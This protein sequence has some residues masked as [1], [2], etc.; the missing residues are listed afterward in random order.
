MTVVHNPPERQAKPMSWNGWHFRSQA[1]AYAAMFLTKIG[2]AFQYEPEAYELGDGEPTRPDFWLPETNGG[3]WLEIKGHDTFDDRQVRRLSAAQ[4]G[5]TVY[6]AVAPLWTR[7]SNGRDT[8]NMLKY[9]G[10]ARL[11][12][13]HEFCRCARCRSWTIQYRGYQSRHDCG[14]ENRFTTDPQF[15][16]YVQ[17]FEVNTSKEIAFAGEECERFRVWSTIGR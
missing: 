12:A 3:V 2:V 4:R 17:V 11:D 6:V 14:V 8:V 1:E 15:A 9:S 10:G 7:A 16:E 13:K 5:T